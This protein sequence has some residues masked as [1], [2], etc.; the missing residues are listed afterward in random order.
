MQFFIDLMLFALFIVLIMA[1]MG[2]GVT[3]LAEAFGGKKKDEAVELSER[4]K[5]GWKDVGS[6]K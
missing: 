1:F 5:Q 4:T 3:K 6:K 2:I